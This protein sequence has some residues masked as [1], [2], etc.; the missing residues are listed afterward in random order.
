MAA[1]HTDKGVLDLDEH[2][3]KYLFELLCTTR[4]DTLRYE[5]LA[6]LKYLTVP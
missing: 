3:K 2:D 4:D 5:L 1:Y 6:F